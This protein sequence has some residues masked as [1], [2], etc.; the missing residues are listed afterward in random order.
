VTLFFK[1]DSQCWESHYL[2]FFKLD[3]DPHKVTA[4]WH[5]NQFGDTNIPAVSL[6]VVK[7]YAPWR[8]YCFYPHPHTIFEEVC[9]RDIAQFVQDRTAEHKQVKKHG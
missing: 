6:G 1:E 3:Q 2:R 9:L 5:V 7:W 4:D 8:K